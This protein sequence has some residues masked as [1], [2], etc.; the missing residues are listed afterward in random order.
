VQ[1]RQEI[2]VLTDS[3]AYSLQY[4]GPP[5]NWTPQLLGDNISIAGPNAAVIASGI[6][7]WMGVDKF[8]RYDGRIQTLRCDLRQYIFSDINLFDGDQ[9]FAG[10]VEGFNEVWWFYCSQSGPDGT[11]TQENPNTIVDRYVVYNYEE[12]VWYYGTMQRTAWLDA[13]VTGSA[14]NNYPLAA[15]YNNNIVWQ[16]YGQN[17]VETGVPAPINAYILS[18]EFDIGDGHNFGFIWRILPDLTFRDS[19]S[20]TPSVTMT[21]YPLTNSGSGYEVPA[22]VGGNNY[23]AVSKVASVGVEQFTGQVYVRVR[24]RQLAFKIESNQLGTTWQLGAPRFD[25]KPD[26][27]R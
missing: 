2:L 26:G 24:G 19:T 12:D 16:E 22:S 1:T 25:I 10:T 13:T 15:T 27:R 3:S 14:Q 17:D 9:F 11:G 8:Y 21:L 23:A 20:V 5:Y 4:V 6:V 7:Y 18:S